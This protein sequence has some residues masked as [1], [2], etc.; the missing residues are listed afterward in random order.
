LK[1]VGLYYFSGTGNTE[2]VVKRIRD[3][4]TQMGWNATLI[5]IED[6]T[7]KKV[8]VDLEQFDLIAIGSQV[9]GYSIPRLVRKFIK[10]IPPSSRQRPVFVFRTCGGVAPINYN[11]SKEMMRMLRRKGYVVFYEQLFTIGS[12][13]I[14]KFDNIIMKQL[15]E[16]TMNKVDIMCEEVIKGKEHRYHTSTGLRLKM[17]LLA[18]VA[19]LCLRFLGKDMKVN[20][21]CTNC[22][23]CVMNC[24]EGNI[25]EKKGTIKYGTSCSACL[26]CV[27]SCPNKA[28]SLRIFSFI[29]IKEGYNV[30]SSL[31]D[32]INVEKN[33]NGRIPPFLC[34]YINSDKS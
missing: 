27:Y 20:H 5:K 22:G 17:G 19:S 2:L 8:A 3:K 30:K 21:S 6:V 32:E 33:P 11:V 15:Y 9:I 12:N 14:M 34:D 25:I 23:L 10:Q 26:R 29:P 1:T 16:A 31:F 18:Q 7:K 24:P 28:I 4:F 13:W